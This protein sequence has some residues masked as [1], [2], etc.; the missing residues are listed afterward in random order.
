MHKHAFGSRDVP[1]SPTEDTEP[2]GD[3]LSPTGLNGKSPGKKGAQVTVDQVK[4]K[5]FT[6]FG[7][8]KTNAVNH[9]AV[10]A[11]KVYSC[12]G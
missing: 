2:Q 1:P 9:N 3:T 10:T 8:L 4:D 5:V 6:T 7:K 11:I 12:V